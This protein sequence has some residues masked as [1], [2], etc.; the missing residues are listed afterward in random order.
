MERHVNITVIIMITAFLKILLGL[1]F[2]AYRKVLSD[3]CL[4]KDKG[5]KPQ[6]SATSVL[7]YLW[8]RITVDCD[9][10]PQFKEKKKKKKKKKKKHDRVISE[11][12]A[13]QRSAL[14]LDF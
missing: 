11:A 3:F 7:F 10:K 2:V 6:Y 1:T 9:V 13:L 12:T 4:S 8:V 5:V 14:S